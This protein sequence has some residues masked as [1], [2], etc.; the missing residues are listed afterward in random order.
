MQPLVVILYAFILMSS[1]LY[2]WHKLLGK[3]INFKDYKLYI[4]LAGMM[5]TSIFNFFVVHNYIRI[6]LLTT[7]FVIFC[8]YL[9]RENLNKTI[10]TPIFAEIINIISEFVYAIVLAI[11]LGGETEK[12]ISSSFGTFTTNT[13]I[14]IML[15]FI[16]NLKITKKLY[17]KL[18]DTIDKIN[19]IQLSLLCI[20]GMLILNIL[21]VNSYNTIKLQYILIFNIVLVIAVLLIIFYSFKTQ[22]KY[23][24]V[25]D[26]YNIAIK[27]L[28]DYEDMM[29]KYRIANHENK[30]L[31]L[32][33]RAMIINKEK[34]IPKYI[35]S[36]IEEK[37]MDDEKLFFDMSVIPSGG[38]RATIYS[39]ILK[40]K[41]RKIKYSLNI[42]RKLK[43]VDLINLDTNA[44]IEICKII[45]VFV[46][47]A[48]EAVNGLRQKNIAIELYM[49]DND[50]CIKVSNN[51]KGSIDISKISDEGYTTKGEGH[52]Y[53][54]SLVKRIIDNNGLFENKTEI[55]KNIFSQI[56]IIKQYS[57]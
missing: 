55:S 26:R 35:D 12:L 5:L 48:I 53:G 43:T 50:L 30:N 38:L 52:G 31:L 23:N 57:K 46:D 54:L 47:N 7:I 15:I 40:I 16:I 18:L 37:Y 10:I 1:I 41:E 17:L 9:F 21:V 44:V 14:S 56:L 45:G 29:T 22:N 13:I 20:V 24:K 27:S 33:I 2:S 49:D 11:I 36:M 42:D 8:K 51:Y 32:T 19:Y 4:T 34:E 3:K 6:I 28:N 25:S 39:E